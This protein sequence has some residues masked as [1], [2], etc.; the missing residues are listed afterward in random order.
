MQVV[1]SIN[2]TMQND[3]KIE[4]KIDFGKPLAEELDDVTKY[5]MKVKTP[6]FLKATMDDLD[7]WQKTNILDQA[8]KKGD[9]AP[10][11]ALP[12]QDGKIVS[13]VDLRAKGPI[14][15]IFFRGRWCA[16]CN[17]TLKNMR[18]YSPHL[19]ARGATIVAISPNTVEVSKA[20]KNDSGVNFSL[21]SD[22]GNEYAQL[23]KIAFVLDE[24]IKRMYD[25][26]GYNLNIDNDEDTGI[27]PIPATYVIESD[28]T[29]AYSFVETNF[30]KRAEPMDVLNAL[31]PLKQKRRPTLSDKLEMEYEK[32]QSCYSDQQRKLLDEIVKYSKSRDVEAKAL[33]EGDKAPDFK[34]Q[35]HDGMFVDS[36]KLRKQGPLV[37]SFNLG[38][39]SP[40]C[41]IQLKAMEHHLPKFKAKG[42][43]IVAISPSKEGGKLYQVD[44]F[45]KTRFPLLTDTDKHTV[46][47][48]FA[49]MYQLPGHLVGSDKPKAE[50]PM[51][52]TYVVDRSGIIL[53]SF[54]NADPA[55]RAEPSEILKSIPIMYQ[56]RESITHGPF[57]LILGARLPPRLRRMLRGP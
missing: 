14:V 26:A 13:S 48:Q 39:K 25:E 38:H 15:V 49:L 31:P 42:A 36:R 24:D 4:E 11:F 9:V 29:V 32:L 17:S 16:Y 56:K 41:M 21:L 53:Y 23:L 27:L 46:A 12:D 52:A 19:R 20:I 33:K 57:S 8:L 51:A 3:D 6:E 44:K 35:E 40:L 5:L 30:M 43:S 50:L 37:I 18:K 7:R 10:D 54:V 2:I 1:Q 45:T 28:G 47:K 55:K 22:L 34:L